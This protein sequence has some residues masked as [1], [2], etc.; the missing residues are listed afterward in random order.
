MRTSACVLLLALSACSGISGPGMQ[1]PGVADHPDARSY[2]ASADAM[3]EVDAAL[4]RASANGKRVIV[5][6]GANWCHDSRAFAGWLDL[7]RLRR[8]TERAF[9]VVYVDIGNPQ[10]GAPRN[11]DVARRF[12]F[13]RIEGTPTVLVIDADGTV[14]NARSARAWRNTASRTGDAIYSELLGYAPPSG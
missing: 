1:A 12:G 4:A 2:G 13:E 10:G 11:M 7:P 8:L 14:L 5:A 6:L 3:A 9:E